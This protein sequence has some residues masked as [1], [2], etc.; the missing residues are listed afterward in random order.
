ML[1]LAAVLRLELNDKNQAGLLENLEMPLARV[2]SDVEAN[3][4]CL[5][6][7]FLQGLSDACA[8]QIKTLQADIYK[9]AGRE[10]NMNA[11]KQLSVVLFEDL[12]LPAVKKT[13]TG[14]STDEG[15]LTKLSEDHE[16]PKL[17]LQYRQLAK[18]KS[19]YI[20]ALPKLVDEHSGRIHTEFLQYGT[21]TGRLSSRHPNLQN[22][23]VRTEMGRQIRRAFTVD[24]PDVQ[25]LAMDYSQIELRIMAHL[26]GDE[27]LLEAF[28]TGQDIHNYTASL[29]FNV[30]ESEITPDMRYAT[31]RVN[32]GIIY[33]ISAFGLSKD[34]K[35]SAKEAQS[36][37][38]TYFERYPGVKKYMVHCIQQCQDLGYVET[39]LKRRR[40]IPDIHHKNVAVRQ[41]AER[42]AINTPVQGSAADLM[43][44]AMIRVHDQ[45]NQH[46]PQCRIVLT[47]HDELI[48]ECP[49]H[50]ITSVVELAKSEMES[51][52]HLDVPIVVTAKSGRTWLELEV[53]G[54]AP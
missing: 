54:V 18:L 13:K 17:I 32:F 3:G 50:L 27:R 24:S 37:I 35:C 34:L 48:F 40:Y 41:F 53:V 51:A 12:K 2:L 14:Y 22:I 47:V 38:D 8:E 25:L 42:Q 21:E 49:T 45:L 44:L 28:Q 29:I 9:I 46:H 19:T 5:D 23:P 16:F 52:I 10:F 11:P 30:A 26:S 1:K 4:I 20:D 33:G 15:V 7:D 39:I 31:K 6:R 36:F 43:K